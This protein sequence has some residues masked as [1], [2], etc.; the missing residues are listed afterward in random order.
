MTAIKR[1]ARHP[2]VHTA[3]E[4]STVIDSNSLAHRPRS[5]ASPSCIRQRPIYVCGAA[6]GTVANTPTRVFARDHQELIDS[7]GT[8]PTLLR[9]QI[10]PSKTSSLLRPIGSSHPTVLRQ[11]CHLTRPIFPGCRDT[12]MVVRLVARANV[13]PHVKRSSTTGRLSAVP[14]C[15]EM[16]WLPAAV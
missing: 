16:L 4:V 8:L 15:E 2:Q 14:Q 12:A 9:S 7:A 13:H 3:Y 6:H 11:C 1:A 5:R 10:S